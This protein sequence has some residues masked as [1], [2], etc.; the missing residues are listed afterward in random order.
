MIEGL[1]KLEYSGTIRQVGIAVVN[2]DHHDPRNPRALRASCAIRGEAIR[3]THAQMGVMASGHSLGHACP[4][5][6]ENAHPHRDW[7]LGPRR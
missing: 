4:P 5:H 6:E 3:L 1:R 2:E 7:Q